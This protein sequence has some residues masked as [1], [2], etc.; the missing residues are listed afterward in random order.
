M[1]LIMH[2]GDGKSY[3]FEAIQYAKANEFEQAEEKL[4]LAKEALLEAHHA[5]TNMLTEEAKGNRLD[6]SLL[7]IHSQDHLMTSMTFMDLAT[8]IID[9]YKKLDQS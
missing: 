8:E 9:I 6:I 5:Q 3:A 1:E 4:A 7:T 2:S